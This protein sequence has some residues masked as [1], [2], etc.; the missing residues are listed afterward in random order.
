M[1]FINVKP[2]RAATCMRWATPWLAFQPFEAI[3]QAPMG[4]RST[5]L[6]RPARLAEPA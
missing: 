5:A 4:N 6:G 2:A 1:C 3:K